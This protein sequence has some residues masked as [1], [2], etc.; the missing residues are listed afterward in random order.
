MASR[1]TRRKKLI[2]SKPAAKSRRKQFTPEQRAK[3][4]AEARVQKLTG[5]QVAKK[6]GISMV[7]YYLWRSKA[8]GRRRRAQARLRGSHVDLSSQVRSEVQT[9]V[10]QILPGV[11]RA[12]VSSYLDSVFSSGRRRRTRV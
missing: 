9:R 12:E 6:Y 11:V 4:L 3:I 8:G 2:T 7:T 5:K 10:R 1:K